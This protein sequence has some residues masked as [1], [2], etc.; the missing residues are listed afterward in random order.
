MNCISVSGCSFRYAFGSS[1]LLYRGKKLIFLSSSFE[2][3]AHVTGRVD[4]LGPL[5][6]HVFQGVLR[7]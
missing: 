7:V 5:R 3:R 2:A 1:L 4:G 6:C